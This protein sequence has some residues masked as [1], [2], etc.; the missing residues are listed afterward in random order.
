M[1]P[2]DVRECV[3]VIAAHPIAGS[4]YG[5]SLGDLGKAWLRLLSSNG[6]CSA[7]MFEEVADDAGRARPRI[8]GVGVTVFV[9]DSFVRELKTRPLFWFGPEM[10][11]RV[12]I[13]PCFPKSRSARRIRGAA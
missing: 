5:S 11:R 7:M 9:S 10:A 3:A 13:R 6:F 12:V 4:R 1:R 2:M 8:V